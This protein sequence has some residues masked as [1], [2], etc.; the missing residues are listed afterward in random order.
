MRDLAPVDSSEI[1]VVIQGPLFR[2]QGPDR[3]IFSCI[4]SIRTYLPQAEIIVS[5]WRD[6]N[7]SGLMA[8]QLVLSDDPGC[9]RDHNGNQVNTNRMLVS[10]HVGVQAA[11]RRYVMKLRADHNLNSAALAVIGEPEP[12]DAGG[13]KL[14][15]TP[16]TLTTLYI[17]NP[18]KVP[19][20]FHISDLVQFGTREA[21]LALWAQPLLKAQ[22]VLRSRP[23]RNPFGN[24]VGHTC[25][26]MIPEQSIMLGAMRMQ[27][28][29][30][31]LTHPCQVRQS[32][33]KV[34][35]CILSTNFRVLDYAES[36]VDYPE[37]FLKNASPLK[38]LYKASEIEELHRR[39]PQDYTARIASVWINQYL[40]SCFRA[41]WWISLASMILFTTSPTLATTLRSYWRRVRKVTHEASYRN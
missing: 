15:D 2:N 7:V 18:K 16:I 28:I 37:R 4:A 29:D 36:G 5:T 34:W 38:T 41:G 40:L 31:K 35:D 33:L 17:R 8:D 3:N 22:E 30:I 32:T 11:K 23:C 39:G 14:F 25:I 13:G 26:R 6:E 12:N 27:G 24:F 9:F 10:T 1:S 19:M 21:M 20:L